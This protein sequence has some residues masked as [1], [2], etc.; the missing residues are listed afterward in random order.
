MLQVNGDGLLGT[1][2]SVTL[3]HSYLRCGYPH[4]IKHVKLAINSFP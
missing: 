2:K 4:H 3:Q 1:V